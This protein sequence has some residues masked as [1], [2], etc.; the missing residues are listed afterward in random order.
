MKKKLMFSIF[1]AFLLVLIAFG[2]VIA[3]A[4]WDFGQVET[5]PPIG[6]LNFFAWL[7]KPANIR[8]EGMPE[9]ILTEENFNSDVGDGGYQ[10]LSPGVLVWLLQVENFDIEAHTDPVSMIFGGLGAF[11][12][13]LWFFDFIWDQLTDTFTDHGVVPLSTISETCPIITAMSYEGATKNVT[14]S[15]LP[16]S[17]YHV[18]RA[19]QPSGAGNQLSSGRYNYLLTTTTDSA[20]V[21]SFTDVSAEESWYVII[22]ADPGTNELV[23]CHSQIAYPTDVNITDFTAT[24]NPATASID[25]AWE[26][27][28]EVD[29]L[30]FN[31]RR[32]TSE[33]AVGEQLN[34]EQMAVSNPGQMD[35]ATYTYTDADVAFGTTYYYWIEIIGLDGSRE[36]VGPQDAFAGFRLFMPF[37]H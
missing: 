18:Y 6:E 25:L 15:H 4:T 36:R 31:V 20:G 37:I 30:G 12:G 19:T 7:D 2:T 13:K 26:T 14:F 17:L 16:D 23:G 35:G 29:L 21:G 8:P 11:S 3:G 33:F 34:E 24:Y 27:A 5:S 10:Q 1:A 32:G 9:Q 28:S 22:R